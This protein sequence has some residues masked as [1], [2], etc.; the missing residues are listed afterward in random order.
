MRC[1]NVFLNWKE[2]G[3][4]VPSGKQKAPVGAVNRGFFCASHGREF[5]SMS[6]ATLNRLPITQWIDCGCNCRDGFVA[7]VDIPM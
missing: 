6:D 7:V 4:A 1:G 2:G 3:R 5:L